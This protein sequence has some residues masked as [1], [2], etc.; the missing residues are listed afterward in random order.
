[1]LPVQSDH[2]SE[3]LLDSLLLG[4]VSRGLLG[5]SHE[6]VVDFDIGAHGSHSVSRI[7][8]SCCDKRFINALARMVFLTFS[9][10]S[11]FHVSYA[12]CMRAQTPAL[13]PNN[14]PNRTATVRDT[15]KTGATSVL[16]K[17]M[18]IAF[19]ASLGITRGQKSFALTI[20]R[21]RGLHAASA[22]SAARGFL[23]TMASSERAAG[24]GRTRPCSQ[25]RS[26]ASGI[27]K[28][29]ANSV[30]VI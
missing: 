9:L 29:C 3:C 20:S 7:G 25:L 30:C 17:K 15:E 21:G 24:S 14:L 8:S 1:M 26:V 28:A 22:L 27:L 12:A 10:R 4:C 6:D 19:S 5:L 16:V 13:S 23:A 2:Q 11:A 18:A